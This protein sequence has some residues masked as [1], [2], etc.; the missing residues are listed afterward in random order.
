MH[1][2]QVAL[3]CWTKIALLTSFSPSFSLSYLCSD[4]ANAHVIMRR[5]IGG[6]GV[7][8]LECEKTQ[9]LQDETGIQKDM[10]IRGAKDL[11]D[12]HQKIG[13]QASVLLPQHN[14]D[15]PSAAAPTWILRDTNHHLFFRPRSFFLIR[16]TL[17]PTEDSFVE[18]CLC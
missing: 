8:N 13:E 6:Y 18:I 14:M 7:E 5:F 17:E 15:S 16:M 9:K 4:G 11:M 12:E 1:Q 10:C 3:M 2:L